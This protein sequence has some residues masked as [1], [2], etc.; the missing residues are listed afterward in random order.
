VDPERVS[1]EPIGPD[2]KDAQT[3][4]EQPHVDVVQQP[5]VTP[6]M[7][8]ERAP[9][10]ASSSADDGKARDVRPGQRRSRKGAALPRRSSSE[11]NR[12]LNVMAI[13]REPT[14]PWQTKRW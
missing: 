4:T 12:K 11:V 7:V 3:T 8:T 9:H 14:K 13:Q 6:A 5:T 10:D 2:I 1:H